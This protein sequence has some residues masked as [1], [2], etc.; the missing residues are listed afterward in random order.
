MD[1]DTTDESTRHM[2]AMC[3]DD[4]PGDKVGPRSCTSDGD[5]TTREGG[6]GHRSRGL[7]QRYLDKMSGD[8]PEPVKQGV[9]A[10]RTASVS[11]VAPLVVEVDSTDGEVYTAGGP[12]A[13]DTE[14]A[15]EVC[16][17]MAAPFL[18]LLD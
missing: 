5:A 16:A 3:R 15:D 13:S 9:I 10:Q 1:A 12:A 11:R 7:S 17:A 2:T 14:E 6:H 18:E 4:A 8:I